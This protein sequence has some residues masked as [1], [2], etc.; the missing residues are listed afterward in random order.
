MSDLFPV[1]EAKV[2][3]RGV[4]CRVTD[5]PFAYNGWPSVCRDEN[6]VLYAVCSYGRLGHICPFGKTALFVSK[7]NGKSW[8]EPFI[9]NDTPLDDRDAGIL[10]LGNGRML[11]TWFCHPTGN[12]LNDYYGFMIEDLM[13]TEFAVVENRLAEYKE[14]KHEDTLGGSFIRIS[15]DYGKTWGKTIRVPISSPHG[16]NILKDGTLLYLGKEMYSENCEIS[17]EKSVIA[18]YK[19][20]DRGNTWIKLSV[21]RKPAD[22][23]WGNFHEPHVVE[24]PDGRLFGAIRAEGK[25]IEHGF[26]V[27]TTFSDNGGLT[28]SDWKCVGV[29]G[30]P[31]HLLLHSSGALICS[32]GRRNSPYGERALISRNFGETWNEEIVID[33]RPSDDDLGY[34]ASTELSDGSI[35]TVYYQKFEDDKK[36]SLQYTRWAL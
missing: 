31:P 7:D 29:C 11:V 4:I 20:T 16:P 34:P 12:Y 9:I 10:Y 36:C 1:R 27:Y 32:F 33:G 19:S 5:S 28:W 22:A 17:E 23:V 6:G 35:L 24:L 18:A 15:D 8:S 26:T 3:D 25:G 14:Y 21:L 2:L 30:S 13:E